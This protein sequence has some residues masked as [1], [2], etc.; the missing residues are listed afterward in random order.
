MFRVRVAAP[1][2]NAGQ[3]AAQIARDFKRFVPSEV[4]DVRTGELGPRGLDVGDE[5]VVWLN[6]R[7]VVNTR[8]HSQPGPG[9]VGVQV[10]A[11]KQFAGMEVRVRNLRVRSLEGGAK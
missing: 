5:M 3:L 8:D 10:H 6:G 11:G 1:I 2:L 4:V 7:E 9:S